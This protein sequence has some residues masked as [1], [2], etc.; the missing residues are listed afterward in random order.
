VDSEEWIEFNRDEG[1]KEEFE[2][3]IK[4]AMKVCDPILAKAQQKYSD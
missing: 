3:H 4:L 1:T 2:R